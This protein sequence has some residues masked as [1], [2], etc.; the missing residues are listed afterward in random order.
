MSEGTPKFTSKEQKVHSERGG[1]V[2][3]QSRRGE[4]GRG[5]SGEWEL[6]EKGKETLHEEALKEDV[7]QNIYKRLVESSKE[8]IHEQALKENAERGKTADKEQSFI[9]GPAAESPEKAKE[10]KIHPDLEYLAKEAKKSGGV[11]LSE[12]FFKK[13]KPEDKEGAPEDLK[14]A[15]F[16]WRDLERKA[17][18]GS[19]WRLPAD[20]EKVLAA[21]AAK[22]KYH[23]L[24]IQESLNTPETKIPA[25]AKEYNILRVEKMVESEL[26][27]EKDY[28]K[29]V[30]SESELNEGIFK[31][32]W[33]GYAKTSRV[34]KLVLSSAVAT[35]AVA[36]LAVFGGSFIGLG[37]L[38]VYGGKRLVRSAFGAAITA[39]V[40]AGFEKFIQ[41]LI[42][43]K[44]AAII[45]K[46][47]QEQIKN[48]ND[49]RISEMQTGLLRAKENLIKEHHRM[50]K[51]KRWLNI[52]K[53]LAAGLVG[54]TAT[55][56]SGPLYES[57]F[58]KSSGAGI[59]ASSGREAAA[60]PPIAGKAAE[61]LAEYGET[62][63]RGGNLWN[64]TRGIAERMG[65]SNTDFNGAW[66]D[67]YV[68]IP[69]K[70]GVFHISEVDLIHPGSK[71]IYDPQSK[72]FMVEGER[73]GTSRDLYDALT[74]EGK[75]IPRRLEEMF[76]QKS[77]LA[78]AA[79]TL[80]ETA[81]ERPF[82]RLPVEDMATSKAPTFTELE[83][84]YP[85]ADIDTSKFV[86]ERL[87]SFN[88][89]PDYYDQ[90]KNSKVKDLLK[91][92]KGTFWD[93]FQHLNDET[94]GKVDIH[95]EWKLAVMVK[96]ELKN[97]LP[98][99]EDKTID[100]AIKFAAQNRHLIK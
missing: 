62:I 43:K 84:G 66:R 65:M 69:E 4:I 26:A 57:V 79:E 42:D 39:S 86:M 72:I 82:G 31:K 98:L 27:F 51:Q 89:D 92:R 17:K 58:E 93:L 94:A 87:E 75:P 5:E 8:G 74:K 54:G 41:P 49:I 85:G 16:E 1:Y 37:L 15:Y 64:A 29:K 83:K 44:A 67:S 35:G 99:V 81:P 100:E 73:M 9:P 91:I 52:E 11:T 61:G 18:G 2:S 46:T 59:V 68:Y 96:T 13:E 19:A 80:A 48:L 21:E 45:E 10:L 33:R 32:L 77:S 22:E 25:D 20:Q 71:V 47:K 56:L 12:H 63:G 40:Y 3:G 38:G 88:I 14:N 30:A 60:V 90:I 95:A 70:G 36:T 76:G 97:L 78:G 50:A 6:T 55:L 7:K 53:A 34:T 23:Q 24:L 28:E